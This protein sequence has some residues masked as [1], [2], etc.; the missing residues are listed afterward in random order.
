MTSTYRKN[1]P[2]II[3]LAGKAGSGKTSVAEAICPKGSI[4][5]TDSSSVMW[6]HIFYALPLYELASIKKNTKGVNERSRKM[7]AIHDVLYDLYG[8]TPIGF[9]PDYEILTAMVGQIE[10]MPIEPEGIKPR[11]FLQKAGDICRERRATCFSDWAIMKSVKMH[12][13]YLASLDEDSSPSPFAIIISDVRFENEADS[14]LKQPNGTIIVFD[15]S[16]ETLNDRIIKRDGKPL[17]EEQKNHH[18]EKQIDVIK[19]KASFILNTD[20]MSLEEQA[21][22][23]LKLITSKLE[24]VGV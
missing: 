20:R 5:S 21:S 24:T 14:I 8:G 16:E 19:Q 22:S 3:G 18:S 11:N 2:I 4:T 10:S 9:V 1:F 7:Y 6:Q 15:A 13:N 12:K 23:T 17:S